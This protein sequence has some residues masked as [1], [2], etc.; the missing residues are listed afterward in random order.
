M[1]K[2]LNLQVKYNEKLKANKLEI[3]DSFWENEFCLATIG[4]MCFSVRRAFGCAHFFIFLKMTNLLFN[5]QKYN[6]HT[7]RSTCHQLLLQQELHFRYIPSKQQ[8]HSDKDY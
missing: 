8:L 6:F 4:A 5:L 3:C 1:S 2:E 7:F